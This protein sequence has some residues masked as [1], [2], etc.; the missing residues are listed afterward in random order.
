MN[1]IRLNLAGLSCGHCVKAV[2]QRLENIEGVAE[3]EVDLTSATVKGNV[4]PQVLIE[5][6]KQRDYDAS[7]AEENHPKA[8]LLPNET[9]L[10]KPDPEVVGQAKDQVHLLLTG[11]NCA[12]CVLKVQKALEEVEQV[13][14]VQVNLADQTALV[15]G[16]ANPQS[17]VAAVVR[18]GYGAEVIEDEQ[19]RREKQYHQIQQEIYQRKHQAIVALGVGLALMI[20]GLFTGDMALTASNRVF[21]FIVAVVTLI[22]LV[23]AGGHFYLRAYQALR[24]KTATM[25]TLVALGTGTAWLYSFMIVVKPMWFPLESRHLYFEASAMIIGLINL[26]KMLEVKAKQRSS[27]ALEHLIDLTPKTARVLLDEQEKVI[28][29]EQVIT[30]MK[31]RLQTGDRIAVDGVLQQGR[32]W[33]D[34]SMLTGEP[35]AVEKQKGD[36]VSAGT[37]VH[38]GSAVILAEEIGHNTRL[39]NIIK[40]VR[41]A[42][43]SK[44]KIGQLVDKIASIFVPIVLIIALFTGIIW[45]FIYPNYALVT[46]TTVLIIACPCALGLATPMS[47]IAGV[48]RAAE[49]GILV[50]DAEALQKAAAVDTLV[51]DKTGTLTQGMPKVTAIYCCQ[52][53]PQHKA[54]QLAA[55]L[56][57]GANHPL[58][59]ALLNFAEENQQP[60]LPLSDFTTL[61]GLGVK[62]QVEQQKLLLGS[63][64]LLQQQHI[65]TENAQDFIDQQQASGA[66]VVFLCIEQQL[67]ALFAI[68]DPLREESKNAIARL[69]QQGYQLIMLTGDQTKTAQAIAEPLELDQV[70]AGVLPEQKA[71]V[72]QHLQQQGH[73]VLMVGDGINDAP[74]L[75][76]ANVS[77]AMGEGSDI[78]IETAEITLMRPSINA[79]VDGLLLAK[80]TLRNMKQNLFGAFVYNSLGI[81]IAAG[82]LYPFLGILLNPMWAGL[83]MALSSITVAVNAN[84]LVNF[85]LNQ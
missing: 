83:A 56:E 7:L 80:A 18:A 71:Q 59:K 64:K 13:T 85:N 4:E 69:H 52:D 22:I 67:V 48:G 61:K 60:L 44:P 70:I 27:K 5:A 17:L 54:I 55:S 37:M 76:Q 46:F 33:V 84:R 43:S 26:G 38:D 78:A 81:P 39:A 57:Q 79:V 6:I 45:Y 35:L 75:A 34:E 63:E 62:G 53:F 15:I 47:I 16:K 82:I 3:V 29:L 8:K 25:D 42:Q 19:I 36:K 41:Q 49:L 1:I 9:M 77:I 58:A 51:F 20:W 68:S 31:L 32:I 11:L 66:T 10:T 40:L 72:I 21:W 12:A 24:N 14:S 73:Q 30:G 74:A 50:R 23:Y 28:P 2:K 65:A